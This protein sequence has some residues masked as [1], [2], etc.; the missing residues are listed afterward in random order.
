ML[1]ISNRAKQHY[2][3]ALEHAERGRTSEAIEELKKAIELNSKHAPSH[4]VLGTLYAKKRLYQDA[5]A[6]WEIALSIDPA[7]KKAH[8]YIQQALELSQASALKKKVNLYKRVAGVFLILFII[9]LSYTFSFSYLDRLYLSGEKSMEAGNY[10]DAYSIFTKIEKT[11][12]STTMARGA[13]LAKTKIDMQLQSGLNNIEQRKQAKKYNEG[14]ELCDRMLKMALPTI[15]VQ[16]VNQ[17]KLGLVKAIIQQEM[18]SVKEEYYKKGNYDKALSMISEIQK[19]Y[20]ESITITEFVNETV[21][22][23]SDWM[24]KQIQE[25]DRLNKSKSFDKAILLAKQLLEKKSTS[26]WQ[27]KLQSII[28]VIKKDKTQADYDLIV[29]SYKNKQYELAY[30]RL[31][32]IDGINLNSTQQVWLTTQLPN[33]KTNLATQYW[34]DI[35]NQ[36]NTIL[37]QKLDAESANKII[38]KITFILIATPKVVYAAEAVYYQ[39]LAQEQ[40]KQFKE[41]ITTYETLA[42]QYPKS[43]FLGNATYHIAGCYEQMKQYDQAI[44]QYKKVMTQFPKGSYT[45]NPAARIKAIEKTMTPAKSTPTPK[46]GIKK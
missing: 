19:Q 14:I 12:L 5:I 23:Q 35:S 41:A 1:I 27:N 28:A 11:H 21:K 44:T 32:A 30:T 26:E 38:Q 9:V 17:E 8:E 40:L 22:M 46:P 34:K 33:I 3:N 20:P 25:I 29:N 2:N 6:E 10:R 13:K 16:T 36:V 15:W 45:G 43:S 24:N 18:E 42:K 37:D 7:S 39:G 4:I 31:T